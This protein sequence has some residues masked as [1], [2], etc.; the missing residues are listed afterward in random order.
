M[1]TRHPVVSGWVCLL[2]GVSQ[3][4]RLRGRA[5]ERAMG[6]AGEKPTESRGTFAPSPFRPLARSQPTAGRSNSAIHLLGKRNCLAQAEA[7]LGFRG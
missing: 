7:D 1:W 5:G 3:A 2:L 4:L 6:R